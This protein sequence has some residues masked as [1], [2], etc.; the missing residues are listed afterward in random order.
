MFLSTTSGPAKPSLE[1][2]DNLGTSKPLSW[3]TAPTPTRATLHPEQNHLE[4]RSGVS[5][6]RPKMKSQVGMMVEGDFWWAQRGQAVMKSPTFLWVLWGVVCSLWVCSCPK[7]AMLPCCPKMYSGVGFQNEKNISSLH[8][9]KN[10]SCASCL[11]Q[12]GLKHRFSSTSLQPRE[13]KGQDLLTVW[14]STPLMSGSLWKA[15]LHTVT[16]LENQ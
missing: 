3:L 15:S 9:K 1:Q 6:P 5:A 16:I 7:L 4:V 11:N 2:M 10:G 12:L 14:P 13:A 8:Q